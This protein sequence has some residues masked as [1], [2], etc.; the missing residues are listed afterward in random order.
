LVILRCAQGLTYIETL[1]VNGRL[2]TGELQNVATV[3]VDLG[4]Q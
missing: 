3:K 4:N 2:K 1:G